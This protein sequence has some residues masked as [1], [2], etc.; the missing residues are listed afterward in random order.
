MSYTEI[1]QKCTKVPEKPVGH[2]E[3]GVNVGRQTDDVIA[4]SQVEVYVREVR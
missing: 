4:H 2:K 3:D 1:P